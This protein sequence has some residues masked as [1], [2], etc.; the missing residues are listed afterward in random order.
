[1]T[2][3]MLVSEGLL[4]SQICK[5][6]RRNEL[7]LKCATAF[8]HGKYVNSKLRGLRVHGLESKA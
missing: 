8:D 6:R 1:V 2:L 3:G 4:G 7:G 5:A